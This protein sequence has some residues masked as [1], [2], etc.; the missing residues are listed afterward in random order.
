MIRYVKETK[1]HARVFPC[2]RVGFRK[3]MS[4]TYKLLYFTLIALFLYVYFFTER[5]QLTLIES[6]HSW[7]LSD[8]PVTAS[9]PS[10]INYGV[11]EYYNWTELNLT[12]PEMMLQPRP[13]LV[14]ETRNPCFLVDMRND[15]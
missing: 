9:R 2:A 5:R 10:I 1:L 4:S 7:T 15:R 3:R 8:S 14:R 11:V 13:R 12:A 6:A